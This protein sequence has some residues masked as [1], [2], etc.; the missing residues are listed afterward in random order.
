MD[1]RTNPDPETILII[2]VIG[3]ILGAISAV[4]TFILFGLAEDVGPQIESP[5]PIAQL[6]EAL[7]NVTRKAA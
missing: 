2:G 1:E 6:D 3:G 5:R 4:A 7:R